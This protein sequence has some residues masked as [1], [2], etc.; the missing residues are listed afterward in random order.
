MSSDHAFTDQRVQDVVIS[1]QAV[2]MAWWDGAAVLRRAKEASEAGDV[3]AELRN[4]TCRQ[5]A[6]A[7]IDECLRRLERDFAELGFERFETAPW[8]MDYPKPPDP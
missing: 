6:A 3:D 2:L 7:V 8:L 5:Y 4:I 1:A